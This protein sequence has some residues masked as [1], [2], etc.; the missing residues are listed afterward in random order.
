[1]EGGET[2]PWDQELSSD[3]RGA[4]EVARLVELLEADPDSLCSQDR[5]DGARE[6][7]RLSARVDACLSRFVGSID[8]HSDHALDGARSAAGWLSAASGVDKRRCSRL[9]ACDRDLR[10]LVLVRDAWRSGRLSTDKVNALLNVRDGVE[11]QLVR[12]QSD[13][14]TAITGVT[15]DRARRL[16]WRWRES[17]LAELDCSPDDP[18]PDDPKLNELR[19]S[20][21][22]AGAHVLDGTFTG[23]VGKELAG[24]IS[25]EIDRCFQTGEYRSDDGLTG[26]Q[27]NADALLRLVRRGSANLTEAGEPK[28]AVTILVDLNRLL[29]LSARTVDELLAWPCETSDGTPVP[30]AQVLDVM[31][32]ATI[33]TVLGFYGLGGRFRP[34][35]EVT[36]ARHANASQRRHLRVRDQGCAWPGCDA[37][38]T[39]CQAHHEPPWDQTHRTSTSELVLL[40]RHHHRLRHEH[41]YTF[42]IDPHGDLVVHRPDGTPLP[43]APPGGLLPIEDPDPPGPEPTIAEKSRRYSDLGSC[44]RGETERIDHQLHLATRQR[45]QQILAEPPPMAA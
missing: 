32:D 26:Y 11:A 1:M 35:G 22:F 12:D 5:R 3:R 25:G 42:T 9:L 30:L 8:V 4:T 24:L 29:G 15:A 45:L 18:E 27:R 23:I 10:H 39:W 6:L 2:T 40:C 37:P 33:N 20:E 21:S 17:A 41:G 36:T 34:A 13:L 31:G 16:L 28:R 14:I 43:V 44:E 7:A 19:I 38:A